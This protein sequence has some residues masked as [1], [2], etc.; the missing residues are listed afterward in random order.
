MLVETY[1]QR[2]LN[3]WNN[4]KTVIEKDVK[5]YFIR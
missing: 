1:Y 5:T 2:Y 4:P 3:L